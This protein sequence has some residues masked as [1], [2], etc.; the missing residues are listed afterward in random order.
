[1]FVENPKDIFTIVIINDINLFKNYF[2]TANH[3]L[4]VFKTQVIRLRKIV[5]Y[6]I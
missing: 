4:N 5:G 3:L 1:M 2:G 6:F